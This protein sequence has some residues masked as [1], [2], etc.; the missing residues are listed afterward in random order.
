MPEEK[1]RGRV[2]GR[3][4]EGGKET[5]GSGGRTKTKTLKET[6]KELG[7]Q[8]FGNTETDP[9]HPGEKER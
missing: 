9:Q 1:E 6:Q 5:E 2:K 7:R 8:T 3:S 4:S